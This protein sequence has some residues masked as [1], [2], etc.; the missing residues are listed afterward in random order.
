MSLLADLYSFVRSSIRA[1]AQSATTKEES[2]KHAAEHH[3]KL[4]AHH[5]KVLENLPLIERIPKDIQAQ[6]KIRESAEKALNRIMESQK[7][8]EITP[9][10]AHMLARDVLEQYPIDPDWITP[11]QDWLLSLRWDGWWPAITGLTGR[12]EGSMYPFFRSEQELM[13]LRDISRAIFTTNNHAAGGTHAFCGYVVRDGFKISVVDRDKDKKNEEVVLR[14]KAFLDLFAIKNQLY[15]IEKEAFIRSVRDGEMFLRIYRDENSKIPSIRFVWCEQVRKPVVHDA[16]LN[17]WYGILTAKNDV[18]AV[19]GYAVHSLDYSDTDYE[20]VEAKDMIHIKRDVDRGV[21]RGLPLFVWGMKEAVEAAARIERNMGEGSAIQAAI[22]YI[23][24]FQMAGPQEIQ[25]V[26]TQNSDYMEQ[27]PWNNN[28]RRPVQ[29]YEPGTVIN[30]DKNQKFIP[31]PYNSGIEGHAAV[32]TLLMRSAASRINAPVWIFSSDA[33]DSN[34]AG[35]LVAE[36]PWTIRCESEQQIYSEAF[37]RLLLRAVEMGIEEGLLPED[38]LLKVEIKQDVKSPAVRDAL[39]EA[40]TASS[41]IQAGVIS[42]QEATRQIGLDPKEMQK[43]N[44]EFAKAKQAQTAPP[45]PQPGAASASGSPR[46]QF[47]ATDAGQDTE[48]QAQES[49]RVQESDTAPPGTVPPWPGA[50]FDKSSHRWHVPHDSNAPEK[51]TAA[52]EVTSPKGGVTIDGKAYPEGQEIPKEVTDTLSPD[53][54]A[55]IH[56]RSEPA[57][58]KSKEEP[59]VNKKAEYQKQLEDHKKRQEA[60][61]EQFKKDKGE[62]Q[63]REQNR[64][65]E[66]SKADEAY[67][68]VSDFA[69]G[70]DGD[71]PNDAKSDITEDG[72]P[73][74]KLKEELDKNTKELK[75]HVE[76]VLSK[77]DGI[78]SDKQ[79][80]KLKKTAERTIAKVEKSVERYKAAADALHE[81]KSEPEPEEPPEPDYPSEPDYLDEE[82][83]EDNPG[84]EPEVIDDPDEPD[85]GDFVV[86]EPISEEDYRDDPPPGDPESYEEYRKEVDRHD[87]EQT[88]KFKDAYAK[89]KDDVKEVKQKNKE[90]AKDHKEEIKKW[91]AKKKENVTKNTAMEKEYDS[92]N[93]RLTK[94]FEKA[95]K[96]FEK[97]TEKRDA[98]IEKA[99]DKFDEADSDH[100][101]VLSD[102]SGEIF[103]VVSA[104]HD[105]ITNRIDDENEKDAEPEEPEEE[106]EPE[107][108]EEE[109]D[110]QESHRIIEAHGPPPYPGAV[111]DETSHRWHVPDS[112]TTTPAA[113]QPKAP[114]PEHHIMMHVNKISPKSLTPIN[115]TDPVVVGKLSK[116]MQKR[117]WVGMPIIEIDNQAFTGSHRL[118]AALIAGLKTVPAISVDKGEFIQAAKDAGVLDEDQGWD[119]LHIASDDVRLDIMKKLPDTPNNEAAIAIMETEVENNYYK[120]GSDYR[121]QERPV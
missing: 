38:T 109:E 71:G 65:E 118:E 120:H 19:I 83:D 100:Q 36:S 22:A 28:P 14:T 43:E 11:W 10:T 51:G 5:K 60:A 84:D 107:E 8:E 64:K 24:E 106:E 21:K 30:T 108:P 4:V 18:Q 49:R 54:Q 62:Y 31:G 113:E 39:K 121:L 77:L 42:P 46:L 104:I 69:A 85:I 98:N 90:L 88:K 78:A 103:D 58:E 52:K 55:E 35:Q 26:A 61:K 73:A 23:T 81:A 75:A 45:A 57:Q 6:T 32:V 15:S 12:H 1:R 93:D 89:W 110:V 102:A 25:S 112:S 29:Q 94:D 105:D 33:T 95:T 92:T 37:Y 17:W 63:K 87:A 101:D 117:G 82:A 41:N 76:N 96:S 48:R 115:E 66:Q 68:V 7:R 79:I 111:F 80:D 50:V 67:G 13:I 3:K 70:F 53:E 2:V 72:K 27:R 20:F 91:E 40:Q 59:K 9:Q 119:D 99:T 47:G 44:D 116:S 114:P 86:G 56:K 97:A 74:D 34:F 16:S